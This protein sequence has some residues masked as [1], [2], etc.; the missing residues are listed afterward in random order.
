MCCMLLAQIVEVRQPAEARKARNAAVRPDRV[1]RERVE[2]FPGRPRGM[3][4]V[5]PRR[6]RIVG[7]AL[8]A[9]LFAAVYTT[10]DLTTWGQAIENAFATA[11][12]RARNAA[13]IP[14]EYLRLPPLR[15]ETPT[16]AIGLLVLLVIAAVLR[17]WRQLF[18]VLVAVTASILSDDA[19]TKVLGRPHLDPSAPAFDLAASYPSGHVVI[20]AALSMGSLIVVPRKWLRWCAPIVLGWTAMVASAVLA[21]GWHRPSDV[22]G[23]ALLV[24]AVFLAAS[25][26]FDRT[27]EPIGPREVRAWVVVIVVLSLATIMAIEPTVWHVPVTVATS[28]IATG[29][30]AATALALCRSVWPS[31]RTEERYDPPPTSEPPPN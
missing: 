2:Q 13:Y 25:A 9:V 1:S 11:S 14:Y 30:V 28:L 10:A 24:C 16:I 5:H 20:V 26:I 18:T 31:Q 27:V 17:R 7:A 3:L 8:A 15:F 22:I 21:L 19:L 6:T 4:D 12:D 29:L 23:A